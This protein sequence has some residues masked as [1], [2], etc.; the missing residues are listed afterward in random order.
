MHRRYATAPILL[1]A[2]AQSLSDDWARTSDSWLARRY[3]VA[4]AADCGSSKP[5]RWRV[6]MRLNT[7]E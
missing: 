5:E 1:G 7:E 2:S 6:N 4:L 3:Y